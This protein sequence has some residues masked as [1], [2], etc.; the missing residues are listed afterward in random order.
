MKIIK[1]LLFMTLSL[2]FLS[3]CNQGSNST[4]YDNR[5]EASIN[6]WDII[7]NYTVKGNTSDEFSI[8]IDGNPIDLECE[9]LYAAYDG[10]SRMITE[11]A[12]KYKDWWYVEMKVAYNQ[13]LSLLDEEDKQNLIKSQTSWESYMESKWNMED[14][15]YYQH[16]YDT[17]GQLRTSLSANEEAEETKARAYSLLEYLYIISGEINLVFGE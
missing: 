13:L 14:S 15:F 12:A 2:I 7:Y 17:V 5:I 11:I 16:K 3:S 9:K 8:L 6:S 10:S 4:N 1:R